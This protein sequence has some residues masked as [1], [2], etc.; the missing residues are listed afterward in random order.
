MS[1][2]AGRLL[3]LNGLAPADFA[4]WEVLPGMGFGERQAWWREGAPRTSPHEGLDLR[5]FRTR[6]GASAALGPGARIPVLWSGAVVSIVPDFLGRS[7]FVA[8]GQVDGAGRRLHSVYGHVEPRPGLA[9]G[10]ALLDG[11]EVG[12]VADPAA[13]RSSVPAHLHLS[14]AFLVEEGAPGP[15]DWAA[16]R[17]PARAL[18]FDPLPLV[19]GTMRPPAT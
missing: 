8:H 13:R 9:P 14:V 17:D 4:A 19:C 18:L 6:G 10:S 2:F 1:D 16:L 5:G 15:L 3:Q 7:V 12:A 11:D